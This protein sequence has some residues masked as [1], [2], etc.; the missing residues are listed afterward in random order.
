MSELSALT[1]RKIPG[2]LLKLTVQCNVHLPFFACRAKDS[3]KHFHVT[4]KDNS[5]VFGFNEFATLQD[6]V[7]HFANQP[8]LGS[9]AGMNNRQ[10]KHK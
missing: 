8:L 1:K 4:R 9:D 2:L 10:Q 5:Y 3:V 7:N 6:F